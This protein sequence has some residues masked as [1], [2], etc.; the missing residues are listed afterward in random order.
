[1]KPQESATKRQHRERKKKSREEKSMNSSYFFSLA[2]SAMACLRCRMASLTL[3][4]S[5]AATP[6]F[7]RAVVTVPLQPSPTPRPLPQVAA[8]TAATATATASAAAAAAAAADAALAQ[9]QDIQ[10]SLALLEELA[11]E[12]AAVF[13]A[14]EALEALP[15]WA[16]R[17]LPRRQSPHAA[18]VSGERS[19]LQEAME[20]VLRGDGLAEDQAACDRVVT[21]LLQ[22]PAR[23]LTPE[24]VRLYL[25]L[26]AARASQ[27][28][29]ARALAFCAIVQG[30]EAGAYGALAGELLQAEH[31]LQAA[32]AA[33]TPPRW[34]GAP[35]PSAPAA[36]ALPIFHMLP[37]GGAH[38]AYCALLFKARGR[39]ALL[40][41]LAF[42]RDPGSPVGASAAA[43]I[44][45]ALAE[46]GLDSEARSWL[47]H[48]RALLHQQAPPAAQNEFEGAAW[49]A[50]AG[51]S[52]SAAA[53]LVEGTI[54][55]SAIALALLEESRAAPQA[56]WL[57]AQRWLLRARGAQRA[58]ALAREGL[59][60]R[61][62]LRTG[63]SQAFAA[64]LS[65]C[66]AYPMST[67]A[68]KTG[69]SGSGSSGSSGSGSSS[70]SSSSSA[71]HAAPPIDP[72]SA[73]VQEAR[74]E[75]LAALQELFAATAAR[76]AA[77]RAL[78]DRLLQCLRRHGAMEAIAGTVAGVLEVVGAAQAWHVLRRR[79]SPVAAGGDGEEGEA[80]EGGGSGGGGGAAAE[81]GGSTGGWGV[82]RLPE[83][84]VWA[85]QELA[86][87][88]PFAACPPQ[89]HELRESFS[90][91][92]LDSSLEALY[93]KMPSMSKGK[94][95]ALAVDV[96]ARACALQEALSPL[97]DAQRHRR[98]QRQVQGYKAPEE[99]YCRPVLRTFNLA[100]SIARR[101]KDGGARGAILELMESVGLSS[102]EAGGGGV[103]EGS[104]SEA[105]EARLQSSVER[106][107][108]ALA[109][110]SITSIVARQEVV[111]ATTELYAARQPQSAVEVLVGMHR[112][113]LPLR[114]DSLS[115]H[116]GGLLSC[117]SAAAP[118]E[119]APAAQGTAEVP[120]A[121]V[122]QPCPR[123]E[124]G[125]EGVRQAGSWGS[126][127]Y[128]FECADLQALGAWLKSYRGAVLAAAFARSSS[129][130]GRLS[131]VMPPPHA[132]LAVMLQEQQQQPGALPPHSAVAQAGLI[133]ALHSFS[134]QHFETC[135]PSAAAAAEAERVACAAADAAAAD[136]G[137]GAAHASV[138]SDAFTTLLPD[139]LALHMSSFVTHSNSQASLH[140]ELGDAGD[141]RLVRSL[142]WVSVLRCA[143]AFCGLYGARVLGPERGGLAG[144]ANR[145]TPSVVTLDVRSASPDVVGLFLHLL[146]SELVLRA[147]LAG[148]WGRQGSSSGTGEEGAAGAAAG[149]AEAAVT[150]A[151]AALPQPLL[152][153]SSCAPHLVLLMGSSEAHVRT[154]AQHTLAQELRLP[155][156]L[157]EQRALFVAA[158]DLA[159][160]VKRR[161][162][163]LRKRV[164]VAASTG[165]G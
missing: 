7:T 70:G 146:G 152:P 85:L 118:R 22:A 139:V 45:R 23:R 163:A 99:F 108:D 3:R 96:L 18:P 29:H 36:T 61:L 33:A 164:K 57:G 151:A 121:A 19:L 105:S 67:L 149:G 28:Q 87:R 140:R 138:P 62:P 41:A 74:E 83:H 91:F 56:G 9:Q 145:L 63:P 160:W 128:L 5:M 72:D 48:A 50:A 42:A 77:S 97:E 150:G 20:K 137:A 78:W 39:E 133:R 24:I 106:I 125:W 134:L 109:T 122:D 119:G 155:Y 12:E 38:G 112:V 49:L 101:A 34:R 66:E 116:L 8:S 1:M 153:S 98:R 11:A 157:T 142:R 131:L 65:T 43:S 156:R 107:F 71:Q 165:L 2:A 58:A 17:V 4:A 115:I 135:L 37:Q 51:G 81:G 92:T 14:G 53:A 89:R 100:L 136:A 82:G 73:R 95:G 35:P 147:A 86:L 161:A 40:E 52:R 154:R 27:P 21:L 6:L 123:L 130:G 93:L 32:L 114:G 110:R 80:E 68:A 15:G 55:D 143:Q 46:A 102:E 76:G 104:A 75:L 60:A 44:A 90:T 117:T 162:G 13:A 84:R 103:E 148:G 144:A 64:V 25:E 69:S 31:A 26:L 141:A 88:Y 59:R 124:F 30:A 47:E 159:A 111:A 132:T 16:P 129:L 94:A 158:S 127:P 120:P 10:G 54:A 79:V 113:G 126:S